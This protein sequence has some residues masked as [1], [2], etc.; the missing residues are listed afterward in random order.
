MI[1]IRVPALPEGAPLGTWHEGAACKEEPQAAR[2]TFTRSHS[3]A[4]SS[5]S[6][7]SAQ[8]PQLPQPSKPLEYEVPQNV[9]RPPF[10]VESE[11]PQDITRLLT[12]L[13]RARRIAVVC[14][15]GV[16]VAAPANIPDFRSAGGL[17]DRLKARYPNA[18]LSSG[19]DLF[20]ARLFGSE[21]TTAL[22]YTMIA[23]LKDMADAAQPTIFHHFLKRLD[24]C[25]RL[26]RVYTQ[27][28]D[29]LEEKA[30]LSFGHGG[31][32]VP[33]AKRK[34]TF[35]RSQSD[36][37][38]MTAQKPLFPRAIPL[39]GSLSTLSCALCAHTLPLDDSQASR[40]ALSQLRAGEAVE[41]SACSASESVREAA[42]L[43]PRGVGRMKADIVLYNGENSSAEQVG[44]CVERD[45]LGIRDPNDGNVPETPGEALARERRERVSLECAPVADANDVLAA[46]FE[47]KPRRR[48]LKPL[49]PDM[50]IVAGTSLKVPGTKRIVREFAK[51]CHA[52]DAGREGAATPIRTLF[53][54]YDFPTPAREWS[55]TFDMWLQGDLQH[56]ALGLC[57]PR[58]GDSPLEAFIRAHSWHTREP[59][60]KE[61]QAET[62]PPTKPKPARP[63]GRA[64]ARAPAVRPAPARPGRLNMASGKLSTHAPSRS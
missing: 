41:C 37:A 53:I 39:H 10:A 59:A 2:R 63:K 9:A 1:V 46:A 44:M 42:G 23:E 52:H 57:E 38:L 48:R 64:Q 27:N 20:D 50:L 5:A 58:E 35:G 18:N 56:A 33:S 3:Y 30:G 25:G 36:S 4:G 13:S 45:I 17:F 6:A 16:S 47:E 43:R 34:R 54:N 14:G 26:Q 40:D 11:S 55:S 24:A 19:K 31:G 15:A 62:P 22:F 51:A 61:E 29:G 28:I 8:L 12:S 7:S 49:P 21:A 60:V 32:D